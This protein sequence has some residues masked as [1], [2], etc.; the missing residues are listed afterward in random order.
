[1]PKRKKCCQNLFLRNRFAKLS[2]GTEIVP[3]EDDTNA[4]GSHSA[5]CD[6]RTPS[7][8][9]SL[10]RNESEVQTSLV[11][12]ESEVQDATQNTPGHNA[13]VPDC[14][15]QACSVTTITTGESSRNFRSPYFFN[16]PGLDWQRN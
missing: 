16:P 2:E 3:P 6:T 12:I 11:R 4:S 5:S 7:D 15:L 14:S 1:M 10:V 8:E 13:N 9:T